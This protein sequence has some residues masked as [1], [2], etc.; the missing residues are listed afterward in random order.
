MERVKDRVGL[1]RWTDTAGGVHKDSFFGKSIY[2]T[3]GWRVGSQISDGAEIIFQ[4]E[5]TFDRRDDG[6]LKPQTQMSIASQVTF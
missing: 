2:T 4:R 3:Y 5:T 1:D 6:S